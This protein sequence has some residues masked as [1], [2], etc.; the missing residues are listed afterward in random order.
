MGW[1][2]AAVGLVA[3][4]AAGA[5]LVSGGHEAD[6]ATPAGPP[7]MPPP[8]LGIAVLGDGSAD[9]GGRCLWGRGRPAAGAGGAGA[10]REPGRPAGGRDG[11]SRHRDTGLGAGRRRAGAADVGGGLD[12]AAS[13][14]RHQR[15]ANRGAVRRGAGRGRTG[16]AGRGAGGCRAPQRGRGR[17]AGERRRSGAD[18]ISRVCIDEAAAADRRWLAAAADSAPAHHRG[19]RQMYER[20]LLVL[21]ALTGRNGAV[22]AGARDGWAYVWPRDASATAIAFAAAGYRA[23]GEAHRPLPPRPRPRARRPL[24]R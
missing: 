8:F 14:A 21:H 15:A 18:P 20:S 19:R 2:R 1:G 6:P 5:L 13:P 12:P 17:A 11:R 9:G 7:G 24:Q 23:E 16:G 4:L 22:A 3:V 10:D